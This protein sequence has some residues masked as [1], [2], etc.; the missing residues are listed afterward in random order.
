MNLGMAC[1]I[2]AAAPGGPRYDPSLTMAQRRSVANGIWMCRGDGTLIDEDKDA[3]PV[4]TL[5]LWKADALS[6]PPAEGPT[7]ATIT[8]TLAPLVSGG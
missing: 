8:G 7:S 2:T 6:P 3:Y 5:E 4:S 1:H